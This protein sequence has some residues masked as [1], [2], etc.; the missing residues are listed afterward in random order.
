MTV[1]S[2]TAYRCMKG[3]KALVKGRRCD[4]IQNSWGFWAPM[5][6]VMISLLCHRPLELGHLGPVTPG[7][8]LCL[9]HQG[10][11][12]LPGSALNPKVYNSD[13]IVMAAD[14]P[15]S[16]SIGKP[17]VGDAPGVIFSECDA[18]GNVPGVFPGRCV[19][20]AAHRWGP[21]RR[22]PAEMNPS[23]FFVD[24]A[25]FSAPPAAKPA[26]VAPPQWPS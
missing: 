4:S 14:A 18:P 24:A 2:A 6:R 5:V 20:P 10:C 1:G 9:Q 3:N 26:E 19:H 16:P 17:T 12:E 21:C 13:A 11:A 15:L 7:H 8:F 23:G 22:S 25:I